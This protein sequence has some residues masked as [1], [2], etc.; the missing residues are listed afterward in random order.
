MNHGHGGRVGTVAI[1]AALMFVAI[2][3]VGI[4]AVASKPERTRISTET[5]ASQSP[6]K[7]TI[8]HK[9]K[10]TL[11]V[12]ANAVAAHRTH[13]GDTLGA[14]AGATAGA[15]SKAKSGRKDGKSGKDDDER[16]TSEKD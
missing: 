6:A 4:A 8:C 5:T 14:C 10:V 12:S 13:H 11:S 3:G 2:G 16:E 15:S 9:G 1:G 7:V